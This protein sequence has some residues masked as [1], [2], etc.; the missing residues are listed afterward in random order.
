C[1]AAVCDQTLGCRDVD[2]APRTRRL[3]WREAHR[4]GL[5]VERVAHTVNPAER[6]CLLDGLRPC[7]ARLAGTDLPEAHDE[8]GPLL[9]TLGEPAAQVLRR[10]EERRLIQFGHG[11]GIGSA[12]KNRKDEF[13]AATCLTIRG[14]STGEFG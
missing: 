8:F 5:S 1:H 6:N 2:P 4:V 7:N 14:C 10:G 12:L 9:V 3:S 11:A 13:Q